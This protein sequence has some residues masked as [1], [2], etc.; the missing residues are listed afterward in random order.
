MTV[1]LQQHIVTQSKINKYQWFYT[2]K[3]KIHELFINSHN[4]SS[5]SDAFWEQFHYG[6]LAGSWQVVWIAQSRNIKEKNIHFIKPM[7]LRTAVQTSVNRVHPVTIVMFLFLS[8]IQVTLRL[9]ALLALMKEPE[10][11]KKKKRNTWLEQGHAFLCNLIWAFPRRMSC[12]WGDALKKKL[13]FRDLVPSGF[14]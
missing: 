3:G 4:F 12:F 7:W 1:G 8:I 14:H 9:V 11:Q 6:S 5:L 2:N 13:E 10:E